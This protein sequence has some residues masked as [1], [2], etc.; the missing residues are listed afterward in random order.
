MTQLCGVVASGRADA[1]ANKHTR[2]AWI[3]SADFE[4]EAE[5]D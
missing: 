1:S 2:K 3:G 4:A 5:A